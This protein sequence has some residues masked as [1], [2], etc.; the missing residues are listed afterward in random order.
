MSH[1]CQHEVDWATIKLHVENSAR[2]IADIKKCL[3]VGN[4]TP[5][6]TTRMAKVEQIA[7][8]GRWLAGV[9]ITAIVG[10]AVAVFSGAG[11]K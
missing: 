4:G 9:V 5:A 6:M 3:L 1:D 8:A 7:D 2:D 10:L 11:H